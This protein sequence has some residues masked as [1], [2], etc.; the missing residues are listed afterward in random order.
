MLNRA[1]S[2]DEGSGQEEDKDN[3]EASA[4]VM[5]EADVQYELWRYLCIFLSVNVIMHAIVYTLQGSI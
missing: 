2:E 5:T 4:L 1:F 3:I